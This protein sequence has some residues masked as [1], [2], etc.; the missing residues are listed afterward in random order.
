MKNTNHY[1]RMIKNS[2][3]AFVTCSLSFSG[4]GAHH[5]LTTQQKKEIGTQ[6][7]H[8]EAG[9]RYDRLVFWKENEKFPSLGI[10]HFIWYPKRKADIYTQTFPDL[11]TFFKKNNVKLPAWLAK[12]HYAPWKTKEKFDAAAQGAQVQE[13][14]KLMFDTIDLQ[15]AF[16]IE[17]L[18]LAWPRIRAAADPKKRKQIEEQYHMLMQTPQGVY[19]VLD[20][21]NFKG[22]GTDPK[23]RYKGKGWG[24]LQVLEGMECATIEN[25]ISA[26]KAT[27]TTRITNAPSDKSHE[28]DWLRGWHNRVDSYKTFMTR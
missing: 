1:L 25:F 24:L 4:F 3:F 27:L 22:E 6:I 23:E 12:A 7:W 11:I 9:G 2:I 19:A 21:L 10:C 18:D 26:A 16:I 8:N 17:R 15:V 5:T 14:R 28:K 13:L 20:Y